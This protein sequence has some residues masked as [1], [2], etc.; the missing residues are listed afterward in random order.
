MIDAQKQALAPSM[1]ITA[2]IKTGRRRLISDL[3]SPPRRY[4][5]KGARGRSAMK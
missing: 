3:L 4:A 1:V 5:H 2:K